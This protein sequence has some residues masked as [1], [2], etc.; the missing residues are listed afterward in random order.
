MDEAS[1]H[2]AILDDP[3]DDALRLVY[4]DWLEENGRSARA[5]WLRASCELAHLPDD[6]AQR[7]SLLLNIRDLFEQCKP[8][9]W[10]TITNVNQKNDRGMFRFIVGESR[11]SRGPT[12]IN[13]LGKVPWL[14]EAA[15]E[16][17]LERIDVMWC[18][19]ELAGV[20][21]GW[22]GAV[23]AIPLFVCP[24]PQIG[25]LGVQ[26]L[27]SLRQLQALDLKSNVLLNPSVLRLRECA[28]LCE[29]SVEFRLVGVDTVN[30]MLDQIVSMCNLRRLRLKGHER[31]EYGTRPN[32]A[33]LLRLS[34]LRD[35]KR[36]YLSSAP[37]VTAAGIEEL[38]RALP[39]LQIEIE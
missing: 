1:F 27:L 38:R 10:A 2:R 19:T 34:G 25:D 4:A 14:T 9:W 36:L 30:V 18:D 24:A 28:K 33:D 31:L 15:A 35:L 8:S 12:P 7:D 23:T 11:S 22:K 21:A 29:L 37:A 13:R 5:A 6:D 17:W 3:D 26:Q 39:M 32:D 20:L 16:G